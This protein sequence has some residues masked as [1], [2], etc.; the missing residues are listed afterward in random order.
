MNN[1]VLAETLA[2]IEADPH[3][4][5]ALILYALINT[6]DYEK[7]GCLFKLNKLRDLG[8]E[9]RRLAYDLMELMVAGGNQGEAWDKAKTRM[10]ERV[11]AG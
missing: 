5:A 2:V 1:D 6:F 9:H 7:A 8:P 10:D 3:S 4:A 11:R